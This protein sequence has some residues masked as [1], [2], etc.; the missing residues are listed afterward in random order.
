MNTNYTETKK[1]NYDYTETIEW[2][3][4]NVVIY[5]YQNMHSRFF[6]PSRENYFGG[7][8][9]DVVMIDNGC[10]SLL[11]PLPP[12]LDFLQKQF[13]SP[14]YPWELIKGTTVCGSSFCLYISAAL[15]RKNTHCNS[16]PRAQG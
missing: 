6:I 14:M 3:N 15:H 7:L 12:S 5:A 13:P 10:N 9:V 4:A 8:K 1:C 11:I 2:C 16:K